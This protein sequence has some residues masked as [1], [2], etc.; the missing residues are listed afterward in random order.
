MP[1]KPPPVWPK[2]TRPPNSGRVK[3]TP[4]RVSVEV[5]QLVAQLTNDTAY[6]FKLRADFRRRKVHPTIEALI[7]SYH[8]GRP[9]QTIDLTA[10]VDVDARLEEEKRIFATLDV[11]ELEDLAAASQALVDR[12][13]ALS[14]ARIAAASIPHVVESE[15]T[16]GSRKS[17]SPTSTRPTSGR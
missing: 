6:Q 3:G 17:T 5:K 11:H 4:N 10:T 8:L 1:R 12:A 16:N 7:W 14:R 2:G 13:R 9:K 15:P